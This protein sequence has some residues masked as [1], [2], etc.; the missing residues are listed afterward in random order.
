ME[1]YAFVKIANLPAHEKAL[2]KRST[3]NEAITKLGI[4]LGATIKL[5]SV[6][7]NTISVSREWSKRKSHSMETIYEIGPDHEARS[8]YAVYQLNY[9]LLANNSAYS[10]RT[11]CKEI[12]RHVAYKKPF[13]KTTTFTTTVFVFY[14]CISK[15]D[16]DTQCPKQFL[17]TEPHAELDHLQ[18][19]LSSWQCLH[20]EST[21]IKNKTAYVRFGTTQQLLRPYNH[22]TIYNCAYLNAPKRR[23][24]N[25]C[26]HEWNF[27][28]L[29]DM[30]ACSIK[31]PKKGSS[32]SKRIKA[33]ESTHN[34][35]GLWQ[36]YF[37]SEQQ[38][39]L[40]EAN[41]APRAMQLR[42]KYTLFML[43][44][45]LIYSIYSAK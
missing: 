27:Q 34:T 7:I 42:V 3:I 32:L 35:C 11:Q 31:V 20:A 5:D 18:R 36:L 15:E 23:L 26:R 16:G 41:H 22:A 40:K 43:I 1:T 12:I 30:I 17:V 9:P 14:A 19:D 25:H 39:Q 21:R 33:L 37:P 10:I 38:P 13:D 29:K 45:C 44:V 8:V 4:T 2:V 24:C 28:Q 6:T